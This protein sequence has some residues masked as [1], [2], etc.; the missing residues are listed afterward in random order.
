MKATKYTPKDIHLLADQPG[1]YRFY[2]QK[3]EVIYV[4]KAKN[5]KKRVS[6]YF[7]NIKQHNLKT[8]RMVAEI[9][10]IECT[11]MNSEYEALLL[12]NNL[13]KAEPTP[14]QHPPQ[15]RQ[16]ISLPLYHPRALS[17][18]L[19]PRAKQRLSWADIMAPSLTR[20]PCIVF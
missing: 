15:R 8:R 19:F 16:D 7:G 12:E 4:G 13:I 3:D 9:V 11:I 17:K 10:G 18:R 14:L 1:V 6:S 5:I 20:G 2:N